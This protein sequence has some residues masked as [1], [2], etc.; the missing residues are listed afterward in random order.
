MIID[1][2]KVIGL[3]IIGMGENINCNPE[4]YEKLKQR[5]KELGLFGLFVLTSE[6]NLDLVSQ[7]EK[8]ETLP[9]D[10]P[11]RSAVINSHD[12]LN[13][14]ILSLATSDDILES[15]VFQR[16]FRNTLP[17]KFGIYLSIEGDKSKPKHIWKKEKRLCFSDWE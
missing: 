16:V 8:R 9:P 5:G 7:D 12:G 10:L 11:R 14:D 4:T 13:R 15:E 2:N 1:P 17:E 6:G 3:L